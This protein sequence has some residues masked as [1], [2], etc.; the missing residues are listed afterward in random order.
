M[1]IIKLMEMNYCT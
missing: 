1:K